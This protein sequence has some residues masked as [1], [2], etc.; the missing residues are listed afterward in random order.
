MITAIFR[1]KDKILEL[2]EDGKLLNTE[3]LRSLEDDWFGLD[4]YDYNFYELDG[5]FKLDRYEIREDD[6][7][8]YQDNEEIPLTITE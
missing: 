4:G 7:T 1:Q 5:K 8:A 6:M 3:T 2:Y